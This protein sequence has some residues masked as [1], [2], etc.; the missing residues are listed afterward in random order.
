MPNN[1]DN[2]EIEEAQ[3]EIRDS[4]E[5]AHELICEARERNRPQREAETRP[6]SPAG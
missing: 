4:L 6:P 2:A 3:A 1:P 5:R